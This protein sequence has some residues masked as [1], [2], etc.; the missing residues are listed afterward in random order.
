MDKL[1]YLTLIQCCWERDFVWQAIETILQ[2]VGV[3]MIDIPVFNTP[4]CED[5]GTEPLSK[6]FDELENIL[7]GILDHS[8]TQIPF[9]ILD[10]LRLRYMDWPLQWVSSPK[11]ECGMFDF[12]ASEPFLCGFWCVLWVIVLLEDP[13]CH[14]VSSLLAEAIRFL[15]K[16]FLYWVK[17]M[18]LLTLTRAPRTSGSKIAP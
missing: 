12:V 7:G 11:T 18:M 14:Q 4:P 17:V 9:Q 2:K 16:M 15:S 10:V 1:Y 6:M 3:K 5:N 8:S 13:L